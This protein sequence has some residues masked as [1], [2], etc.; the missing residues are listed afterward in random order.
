M[1]M[2]FAEHFVLDPAIRNYKNNLFSEFLGTFILVFGIFF[3]VTPNIEIIGM[4]TQSFG[5]GSLE[6][7]SCWNFG[8]GNWNEF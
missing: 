3:I 7:P 5:I 1:K 4:E 2:L 8:L 6:A